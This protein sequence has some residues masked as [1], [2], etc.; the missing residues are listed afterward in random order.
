M[1]NARLLRAIR[2]A[3][4]VMRGATIDVR[5]ELAMDR[6]QSLLREH[7]IERRYNPDWRLQPRVPRRN[8]GGG[9]WTRGPGGAGDDD[10][11]RV[12]SDT[13]TRGGRMPARR[14]LP[15]KP[16]PDK[17]IG[18]TDPRVISDANPKN[19]WVLGEQY[20]QARPPPRSGGGGTGRSMISARGTVRIGN[21]EFALNPE[22]ATRLDLVTMQRDFAI[23]RVREIEPNWRPSASIY[24]TVE[25][26]ISAALDE[27]YEANARYVEL[28]N[29][30]VCPGPYADESIPAR[31]EGRDFTTSEREIINGLGSEL[32]CHT[33]GTLDPGTISGNFVPDH[34]LPNALNPTNRPQRLYPQCV[35]CSNLQGG[36]VR[37]LKSKRP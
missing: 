2:A 12:P 11:R 8:P 9:Q 37:Y 31:G 3:T 6:F 21:R 23:A 5:L 24:E 13:P 34:Q 26:L 28:Q 25:E 32:G 29:A 10:D 35:N 4:A 16:P 36:W 20:A 33:C 22:T 7:A 17:P 14:A 18:L 19:E 15:A 27:M 30:G 1:T